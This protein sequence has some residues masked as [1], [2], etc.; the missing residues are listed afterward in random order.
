VGP[1]VAP[2]V[3]LL[4][5]HFGSPISDPSLNPAAPLAR[6]VGLNFTEWEA[7]AFG[8]VVGAFI[9][10]L[11][12]GLVRGLPDKKERG[13]PRAMTCCCWR[14]EDGPRHSSIS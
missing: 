1:T 13:R 4:P 9:V 8:P 11:I 5:G 6:H 12:I 14:D 7:Y 3:A 2:T 10:A